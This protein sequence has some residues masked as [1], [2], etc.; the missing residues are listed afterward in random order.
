MLAEIDATGGVVRRC[1]WGLDVSGSRNGA[2]G[3]GGL[4]VE[5][6]GDP[7]NNGALADCLPF[8][9]G[10]GNIT[11]LTQSDNGAEVARYTFG[12]F[13]ESIGISG[14]FAVAN[15]Y[16]WSTKWTEDVTGLKDYGYRWLG[17]GRW[18]N[19]DPMEEEGG[20]N[21][22]NYAANDGISRID[23]TGMRDIA[24]SGVSPVG[25]P[26][27]FGGDQHYMSRAARKY[28]MKVNV[29]PTQRD[30][31]NIGSGV[32]LFPDT[33]ITLGMIHYIDAWQKGHQIAEQ[34]KQGSDAGDARHRIISHSQGFTNALY[35][36]R[37]FAK[38]DCSRIKK[39]TTLLLIGGSP[40][41]AAG[42]VEKILKEAKEKCPC[43]TVK[44]LILYSDNDKT[45]PTLR[46]PPLAGN[47]HPGRIK[48]VPNAEIG[49]PVAGN[50]AGTL[51]QRNT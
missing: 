38:F 25:W 42:S 30:P 13:G 34:L 48:S 32:K 19:R 27:P 3:I 7:G 44:L 20:E 22:Y 4:L 10:N 45:I 23:P 11:G 41:I 47:W 51:V 12:P 33:L 37:E 9:D 14:L 1:L 28:G 36:I 46:V 5:S 15:P 18:L 31:N 2:G 35:G 40:K 39:R 24:S 6:L 17:D 8:Y 16:R 43:L 50:S 21:L 29:E 26:N 49:V